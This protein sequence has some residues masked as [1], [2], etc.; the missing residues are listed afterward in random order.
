MILLLSILLTLVHPAVPDFHAWA[1]GRTL[2]MDFNHGGNA[3]QERVMVSG[4][5]REGAWAGSRTQLV[6]PLD[7]GVCRVTVRDAKSRAILYR[8]GYATIFDEWKTTAPA[9]LTFREFHESVRFPEPRGAIEIELD[10]RDATNAYA[11][12]FKTTFD[13]GQA[14]VDDRP[15]TEGTVRCVFRNGEPSRKVDL[16]L[17]GDGY[18]N[19]DLP[20]FRDHVLR[21]TEALFAVEPYRSRRRD[22]NVWAV[23]VASPRTGIDDRLRPKRPRRNNVFGSKA[24]T[25]GLARYVLAFNNLALREAAARAPCDVT[26]VLLNTK[27]YGGGGIYN[28]YSTCAAASDSAAYLLIHEFGHNFAALADEYYTS[29][30]AYQ[31]VN[32]PGVEPW[33]ANITALHDKEQLKWRDL[34]TPD[35]VLPTPWNQ[36]R[37]DFVS[38]RYQATRQKLR[39]AGRPEAELAELAA[40]HAREVD[41]LFANAPHQNVVGA[42]SGAGY[43]AKGLYRPALDCIMFS[44]R[45]KTFCPVCA[46][47]I[48]QVIDSYAK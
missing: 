2:R 24:G 34:V 45:A 7:S 30:V 6:S 21:L 11:S 29:R 48:S 43:R 32:P 28:L 20:A 12:F 13:P 35:T 18:A 5:R 39:A 10:R 15:L 16:V 46:R 1:T 25:F 8:R 22:F 27:R 41:T 37:F 9:R 4:F 14:R 36:E 42:F 47:A 19:D 38:N 31:N 3:H 44:R 40:R 17:V 23:E 33:E 26:V